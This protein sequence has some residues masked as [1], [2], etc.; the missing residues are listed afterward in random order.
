MVKPPVRSP[1]LTT[2]LGAVPPLT[3]RVSR[4]RIYPFPAIRGGQYGEL[5]KRITDQWQAF[6]RC[7]RQRSRA[8]AWTLPSAEAFESRRPPSRSPARPF[9]PCWVHWA[10]ILVAVAWA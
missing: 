8:T 3:G 5:G 4:G 1:L 7:A 10:I 2:V 9:L 6:S